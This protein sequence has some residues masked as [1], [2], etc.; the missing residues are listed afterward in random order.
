MK[1]DSMKEGQCI[2]LRVPP[3]LRA[4]WNSPN[5][6]LG[7]RS[8]AQVLG[9]GDSRVLNPEFFLPDPNGTR[10]QLCR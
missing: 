10:R 2:P 8:P 5:T 7:G 4:I 6:C 9:E 3:S 1:K